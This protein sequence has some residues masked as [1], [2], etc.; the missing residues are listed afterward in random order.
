MEKV[1]EQSH[2][3]G[4][5]FV[6][7]ICSV[8]EAIEQIGFIAIEGFVDQESPG[9][10]S[11]FTQFVQGFAQIFVCFLPGN[12]ISVVSLHGTNDGRSIEFS[13][14]RNHF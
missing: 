12:A 11:Q 7:K 2:S 3:R 6:Q 8:F 9:F 5:E 4:I 13:S 10:G 1:S 14:E